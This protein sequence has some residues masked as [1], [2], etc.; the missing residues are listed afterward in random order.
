MNTREI[1][2]S[3]TGMFKNMKGRIRNI[4]RFKR[5][6]NSASPVASYPLDEEGASSAVLASTA[7][8]ASFQPFPE[9]DGDFLER[10]WLNAPYA[11]TK[12]LNDREEGIKYE[13]VEPKL[14]PR[15][16]ILLEEVHS[17]YRD[18]LI[19]DT[20]VK[21]GGLKLEYSE[22]EAIAKKFESDLPEERLSV[23]FYYLNRNFFGYGRL[24]PMMHDP[25]LEDISCNGPRIP[26]FVY[27]RA[28]GS[29]PSNVVF[30]N[31][32]MTKFV[33]KL[34]QKADKQ[35]SLSTPLVDAHMPDG[36]RIQLTFSD[37]VSTR[38]SSFTIRKFKSEPMTPLNLIEYGTFDP[39][40]LAFIW[41][42]IENRT[43]IIICGG[44][45]SGKTSTMNALSFFIPLN[46]KIVSLEDTREIQLPHSN[47]LPLQTR[48]VSI[49]SVK[50][51]IDL[52]SLLKSTLRQ[53]PEFII[54]G[55]VRGRE[56][57]TLF[58]AM[59][60]GHTTF[61][62]LHAGDIGEAINRLTNE[63]I[64]VPTVMFTAL[65]LM[66]IQSLHHR[67]GKI[68]RRCDAIHE[69][70]VDGEGTIQFHPLYSWDPRED[71]F[72]LLDPRSR[73][74]DRIGRDHGWTDDDLSQILK[75]RKEHI[76]QL[77]SCSRGG[78]PWLLKVLHEYSV[79][80][81]ENNPEQY[82]GNPSDRHER[83]RVG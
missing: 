53:R 56:A 25:H 68:I 24:D 65:D 16:L 39:E 44:T 51:E 41:L 42:A 26:V 55:E 23:L 11:Y 43:S 49:A 45:A 12:I 35:I 73:V 80:D 81:R 2:V 76:L 7:V 58:Q 70:S 48:E 60:T 4:L 33:L 79:Q 67:E 31:E 62:T 75:K 82:P 36:S 34:A 6:G 38:G 27:H 17:Y 1:Q 72:Q 21:Q 19:Y 9:D 47:W 40:M 61:S 5:D 50:G 8:V 46:A 10:Y 69:M 66:I 22:F 18:V 59:N 14:A 29:I 20:P 3:G 63:P 52:F 30:G 64:S 71:A 28:Y 57:Q 74:L 77:I 15:E 83:R 37:V 78:A 13:I 32:E 54:V